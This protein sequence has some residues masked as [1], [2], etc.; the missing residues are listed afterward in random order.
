MEEAISSALAC[1]NNRWIQDLYVVRVEPVRG[2]ALLRVL[3]STE[4]RQDEYEQI[5]QA[6]DSARGYFRA[7][8]ARS[9]HRKRTPS[10][11]FVIVPSPDRERP[12]KNEE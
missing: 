7:E 8:V 11:E 3:V 1:A 6:L 5:Q 4:E 2:A 10:L 12:V 9:I